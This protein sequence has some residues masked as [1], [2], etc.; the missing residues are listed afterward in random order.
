VIRLVVIRAVN[1]DRADSGNLDLLRSFAVLAVL[2]FHL[3]LWF[4]HGRVPHGL[5]YLGHWGV[6]VFFVHTSIVLMASLERQARGAGGRVSLADFLIRRAFRL[7]PLAWVTI[8]VIVSFALPVGHLQ[9]GRFTPVSTA[10]LDVVQNLLLIQNL[11]GAESLE[12]PL[13]SLPYEMQMYLVLPALFWLMARSRTPLAMLALWGAVTAVAALRGHDA[14]VGLIDYAPCFL[15]GVAGYGIARARPALRIPAVVWPLAIAGATALYLLRPRLS[16]GW[17][18]CLAIA[19]AAVVVRELPDGRVRWLCQRIARYSYGVYLV[20]FVLIWFAFDRLAG[21]P[22]PARFAVF[23]ALVIALPIAL[24]HGVER[25]MIKVGERV[26]R[27]V[28][29]RF[30]PPAD[31]S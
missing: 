1:T 31:R 4:G 30:S 13:W 2:V 9:A 5:V 16:H 12:A 7:L 26:A 22:E 19:L 10:P 18:G 24:Y 29:Q 28:G 3:L 15:A 6:L 27:A 11:G 20:H 25:P 14:E 21:L 17:I 8:A 23:A